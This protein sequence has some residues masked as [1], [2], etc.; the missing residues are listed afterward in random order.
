MAGAHFQLV[1]AD[2]STNQMGMHAFSPTPMAPEAASKNLTARR[3]Q[4]IT[5]VTGLKYYE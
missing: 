3:R 4:T 1:S 5:H 2:R